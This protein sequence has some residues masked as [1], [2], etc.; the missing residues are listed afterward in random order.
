MKRI[1]ASTIAEVVI[2]LTIIAI[3]FA[4]ASHIFIQSSLSTTAFQEVKD[5]TE[6]QSILVDALIRDTLPEFNTWESEWTEVKETTQSV[7]TGKLNNIELISGER[8]IWKQQIY[9]GK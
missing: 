6:F 8:K 3:C 1:I 5:Q 7:N 9:S 4:I 2:A